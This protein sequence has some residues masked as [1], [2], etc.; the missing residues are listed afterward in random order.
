MMQTRPA[1]RVVF[2][3]AVVLIASTGLCLAHAGGEGPDP[4]SS[5]LAIT[6]GPLLPDVPGLVAQVAPA[7][8]AAFHPTAL[9]RPTP[10]PKA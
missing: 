9:D 8:F 4:C 1:G 3:V 6:V 5:L 10:P 2:L 7:R